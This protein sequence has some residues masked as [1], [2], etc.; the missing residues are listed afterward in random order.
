LGKGAGLR[1]VYAGNLPGRIGDLENTTCPEC[2]S[3]VVR[4]QGFLVL[5]NRV[6]GDGRCPDCAASI[7]GRWSAESIVKN[8]KTRM[9]LY[10][11]CG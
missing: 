3:V 8:R 1:Y 7:P 10:P 9:F 6:T 5:Q 2:S 11:H 4:R